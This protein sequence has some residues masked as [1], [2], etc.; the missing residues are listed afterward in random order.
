MPE[1]YPKNFIMTGADSKETILIGAGLGEGISNTIELH[2]KNSKQA[3]ASKG[4]D[5]W[6][7]AI[8]EEHN[9]MT[10]HEVWTAVDRSMVSGNGKILTTTWAMKKGKRYVQSKSIC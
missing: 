1:K 2:V 9:R 6:L 8:E 7:K 10:N 3:M 4:K 5:K